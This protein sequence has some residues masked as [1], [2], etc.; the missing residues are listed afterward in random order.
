MFCIIFGLGLRLYSINSGL[1]YIVAPDE[2][3]QVLDALS[4]G[5]R[6]SLVPLEYTYPVLHKYILLFCFTVYFFLGLIFKIFINN[7]DFVFKFLIDPGNVFFI[8]RLLSAVFGVAIIIP[9]YLMGK[10]FFSRNTGIIAVIFALFMFQL[11]T[12]SQW[13]VADILLTFFC[14]WAFYYILRCLFFGTLKD[15]ILAAFFIGLAVATKY[16]GIYLVVPYLAMLLIKPGFL[17]FKKE[18]AKK[19]YFSILVIVIFA[20]IGNLGLIFNFKENIRRLLEL[21]GEIMGISSL[22]PF[23]HNFISVAIWFIKELIRQEEFLGIILVGGILYSICKH[24]KIDLLFL[25]YLAFCLLTLVPFGFRFLHLLVYSFAIICVFGARLT[26]RLTEIIFRYRYKLSNSLVVA[27]IIVLPSLYSAIRLDFKRL[28]PDTRLLAKT[29]LEKNIPLNSYIAED[30]YDFSVPLQSEY[31]LLFQDE[32]LQK[33]Y[34]E[35]N[36]EIRQRYK[37]YAYSK[38]IYYLRQIR[39]ETEQPIWPQDMSAIAVSL[40]EKNPIIKRLYRWFNFYSI[41]ELKQMGVS[42]VILS[43]YT[44]NHFLLDSDKRKST[45][46][47]NPHYKEDTLSSNKQASAYREGSRYGLIFYLAKRARDFYLPLLELKFSD[48]KLVQEFYPNDQHLGPVI[49][50]YKLGD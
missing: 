48:V 38:G 36:S 49:E 28:Q 16:Q 18:E 35:F 2:K 19:I 40:A 15:F 20:I 22:Q 11:V 1:P 47:F 39:Y 8:A 46:L 34:L 4:M 24:T 10:H 13:A 37:D 45:G 25:V 6:K 30:L 41:E 43:S 33:Y 5:A 27:F 26:E 3:R 17:F 44:Y 29:W 9:V 14:T 12:H 50:I 31:P 23:K 21:R 7:S 32:K 42:V